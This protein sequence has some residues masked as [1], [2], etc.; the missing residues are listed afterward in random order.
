MSRNTS[1]ALSRRKWETEALKRSRR[2]PSPRGRWRQG[3]RERQSP[4]K[5][6][7]IRRSAPRVWTG[8]EPLKRSKSTA[9]EVLLYSGKLLDTVAFSASNGGE[10]TSS[11]KR[12]GG[13][14]PYLIRSL[15]RGTKRRARSGE[16]PAHSASRT[17]RRNEFNTAQSSPRRS[18]PSLTKRFS[19]F[20]IRE[21]KSSPDTGRRKR[22]WQIKSKPP[23]SSPMLAQRSAAATVSAHPGRCAARNSAKSGRRTTRRRPE[24]CS[25]FAPSGTGKRSG[26]APDCFAAR[27]ASCLKRSARCNDD[28]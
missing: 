27:G 4:I 2:R 15:T 13:E 10:T 5:A 14:R 16:T 9:G 11:A 1:R 18:S 23:I 20:I 25:A 28:F 26:I 21:Q 24:I 8:K 3:M 6:Q 19:L 7:S 22:T 17:R 12:W